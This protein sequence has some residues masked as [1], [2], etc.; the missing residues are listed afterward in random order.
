MKPTSKYFA[1][2]FCCALI[3]LTTAGFVSDARA[4]NAPRLHT[5]IPLQSGSSA[6]ANAFDGGVRFVLPPGYRALGKA[7]IARK[8]SSDSA[9][10]YVWAGDQKL[11]A[12]IALTR[13]A[14]RVSPTE[15]PL[16]QEPMRKSLEADKTLQWLGRETIEINGQSWIHFEFIT[17]AVDTRI[18]NDLYFTSWNGQLLIFNFNATLAQR[19]LVTP[20][21]HK[22]RDS[23]ELEGAP[24]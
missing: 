18:Y 16:L 23:V 4:Q 2:A 20:L 3:G 14:M 5:F 9:P 19:A 15:L 12:T 8:F 7:E 17:Q 24:K 10:Q 1:P 22:C 11:S 6:K 13:D 21:F